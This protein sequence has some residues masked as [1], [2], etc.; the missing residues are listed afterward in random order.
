M[1]LTSI[2]ADNDHLPGFKNRN[3]NVS[4]NSD[5]NS[6]ILE[7]IGESN[8][9]YSLKDLNAA[10]EVKYNKNH[11]KIYDDILKED[12][13]KIVHCNNRSI[14]GYNTTTATTNNNN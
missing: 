5:K 9:K 13:T 6:Q 3:H 2:H 11:N 1:G 10:I 4:G 8:K 7:Q 14:N 12:K